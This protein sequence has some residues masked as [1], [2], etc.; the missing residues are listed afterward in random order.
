MRALVGAHGV[1][2]LVVLAQLRADLLDGA[3]LLRQALGARSGLVVKT[4]ADRVRALD[5]GSRQGLAR[6]T[7]IATMVLVAAMIAMAAAMAGMIWQRRAFLASMKVEG[8]TTAELRRSLLLQAVVLVGAG[9]IVGAAFGLLGQ[10]LLSRALTSVTGFPVDYATAL[11]GALASCAL[12]TLVAVAIIG[13]F[14]HRAARIAAE[15]GVR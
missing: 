5:A 1:G 11:L 3:R 2:A 13:A 8:Y 6:L 9:C 7:Q 12:V 4:A 10:S 15:V 14:G